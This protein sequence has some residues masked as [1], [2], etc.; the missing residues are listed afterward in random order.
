MT[1]KLL[2]ILFVLFI[3][4]SHS[5]KFLALYSYGLWQM[6]REGFYAGEILKFKLKE[7]G[8]RETKRIS[9]MKDSI[10]IFSD[11]YKIRLNEISCIYINRSNYLIR[12]FKKFFIGYGAAFI[13]LDSFNNLIHP[14][15]P[16]PVVKMRAVIIGTSVVTVGLL[17][18]LMEIKYWRPGKNKVLKVL[19][20]N[21]V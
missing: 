16:G 8:I 17:I 15:V 6:K 7:S 2:F 10:I 13:T 4:S 21:P 5:Q 9:D 14:E 1:K 11:G 18:K 12:K 20:L 3:T 19:D